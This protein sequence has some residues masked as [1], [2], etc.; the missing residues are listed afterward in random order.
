MK[1]KK[2]KGSTNKRSKINNSKNHKK[3]PKER[4]LNYPDDIKISR[5]TKNCY[6]NSEFPIVGLG[7]EF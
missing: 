3:L 6:F 5:H 4:I 2:G 1:T 7:Q